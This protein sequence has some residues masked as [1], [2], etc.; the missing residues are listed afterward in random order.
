MTVRGL[1]LLR[2][3]EAV[4]YDRLV[5]PAL[6]DEAPAAAERVYVGKRAGAHEVSQPEINAILVALARRG[7]QVV[8]LKG[9]D[10]FVFGRGG[11]EAAALAAAGIPCEVVPGVSAAL[12]APAAAGIPVTHRGISA[13]F[14]VVTGHRRAGEHDVDWR[15]LAKVGGTIVVLMGVA[16]RAT[17]AAELI[18]G[19]LDSSTPVAAIHRATTDQQDVVRC[20][21]ADLHATP[22][23]SPAVIVIGP[24]A[25]LDL[26]QP[27]AFSELSA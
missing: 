2:A 7:L 15:S 17:I 1:G 3:A 6:L 4:V 18:A 5:A 23:E 20:E 21:L 22:V 10:P 25:A 26:T 12:A 8:R 27:V 16:Q 9:G 11:E 13:A 19:G 24:V 14:T